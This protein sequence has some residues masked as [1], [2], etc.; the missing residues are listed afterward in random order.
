MALV[1]RAKQMLWINNVKMHNRSH[2]AMRFII[3]LALCLN[4]RLVCSNSTNTSSSE[5]QTLA[6]LDHVKKK[7]LKDQDLFRYPFYI[8][9][10]GGYGSTTWQG[11]VPSIGNQNI[12]MSISTPIA[13]KE[14]G[15]VWGFLA[16]YE[17][18]RYFAIEANYMRYPDAVVTFDEDSLFAFEQDGL[19]DLHTQT[20]TGSVLAKVMLVIPKTS[21][22]VYSGAGVASVWRMDDIN[23]DYRISPT[24]AFGVNVNFNARVMGEIGANYTAGYGE[25]EINPANDFVPFL[26]SVFAKLALRF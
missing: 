16:G 3:A 17:L 15:G 1:V 20:Q 26:Y 6:K 21:M 5:H 7:T 19:T 9:A 18:T 24:F 23:Q 25:S 13:V 12:A 10:M 22:R 8:G 4:C 2:V 14:G 11:L